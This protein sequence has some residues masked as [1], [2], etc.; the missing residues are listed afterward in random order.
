MLKILIFLCI[1]VLIAFA[2]FAALFA[3]VCLC[4]LRGRK[5]KP[6][7]CILVLSGGNVAEMGTHDALLQ[8]EDGIYS[9]LFQAQ[10]LN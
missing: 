8:K 6:A 4:A 7:D 1:L 5:A 3:A 2:L 9:R 10:F